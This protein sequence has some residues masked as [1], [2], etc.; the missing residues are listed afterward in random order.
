MAVRFKPK[1]PIPTR[2]ATEFLI[3]ICQPLVNLENFA[4][5]TE[6]WTYG[7]QLSLYTGT[8]AWPIDC[9]W[10]QRHIWK[11]TQWQ[12]FT[13]SNTFYGYHVEG[14]KRKKK[15]KMKKPSIKPSISWI[16]GVSLTTV[17]QLLPKLNLPS[18]VTLQH[19]MK[20]VDSV[21]LEF[22]VFYPQV[23]FFSSFRNFASN[24]FNFRLSSGHSKKTENGSNDTVVFFS[25]NFQSQNKGY[26]SCSWACP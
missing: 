17:L 4:A 23:H 25:A 19:P 18:C 2:H 6:F 14:E 10:S 8:S 12:N 13:D 3:I 7:C 1:I 15:M 24:D 5:L 22:L 26:F 20:A 11:L 9:L 16:G 21:Q